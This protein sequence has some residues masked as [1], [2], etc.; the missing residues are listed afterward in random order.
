[1]Q[2]KYYITV[3]NNWFYPPDHWIKHYKTKDYTFYIKLSQTQNI[4]KYYSFN[5]SNIKDWFN[6]NRK[7]QYQS[8]FTT[9]QNFNNDNIIKLHNTYNID[10]LM[11]HKTIYLDINNSYKGYFF[12][13][14]Y[15]IDRILSY[16]QD[17]IDNEK[18][19]L[20]FSCLK[21][22]YNTE[23]KVC[24]PTIDKIIT[25]TTLAKKTVLNGIKI[26]QQLQLIICRNVGMKIFKSQG[27]KQ[28]NN[29]YTMNYTGNKDILDQ[30][31]EL[32]LKIAADKD[33]K[34][35]NNKKA[36]IKRSIKAKQRHLANKYEKNLITKEQYTKQYNNL[37]EQYND[38][39]S[40]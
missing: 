11:Q 19:L 18:L 4:R 20:L 37:Q 2:D 29:I 10:N 24:Y 25:E 39:V 34:I 38:V 32:Q 14:D 22:H 26:L 6:Y 8:I 21:F 23:T 36:N 7:S 15:E 16:N 31:I 17:D 3:P 5:L 28:G 27:A 40:I 12:L 30:Y 13:Y 9:L 1:M 33:I 35:T